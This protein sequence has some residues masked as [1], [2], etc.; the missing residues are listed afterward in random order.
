[1]I[2]FSLYFLTIRESLKNA[3][4]KQLKINPG[5]AEQK[6]VNHGSKLNPRDNFSLQVKISCL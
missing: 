6:E 3:A 5:F 1:M 4:L 2:F